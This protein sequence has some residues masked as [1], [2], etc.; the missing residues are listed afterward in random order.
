SCPVPSNAIVVPML[1][2]AGGAA[3]A[4]AFATMVCAEMDCRLPTPM[5]V[6]AGPLVL[7]DET[8]VFDPHV[9]GASVRVAVPVLKTSPPPTVTPSGVQWPEDVEHASM[10]VAIVPRSNGDVPPVYTTPGAVSVFTPSKL[11]GVTA[12]SENSALVFCSWN[13]P[14]AGKKKPRPLPSVISCVSASEAFGFPSSVEPVSTSGTSLPAASAPTARLTPVPP[15]RLSAWT[16]PTSCSTN[17]SPHSLSCQ[18]L[19]LDTC[20]R[21]SQPR[22][23]TAATAPRTMRSVFPAPP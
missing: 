14:G 12:V 6:H 13:T 22:R 3:K 19:Q 18:C 8:Q 17:V 21:A 23:E 4:V 1:V 16:D 15:A 5:G 10:A 20:A 2:C 7:V 9:N 11:S